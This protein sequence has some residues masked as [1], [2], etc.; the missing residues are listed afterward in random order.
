MNFKTW[1]ETESL[2]GDTKTVGNLGLIKNQIKACQPVK[3]KGTTVGRMMSAGSKIG[4]VKPINP[5]FSK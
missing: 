5:M 3:N 1:L 4:A 2:L